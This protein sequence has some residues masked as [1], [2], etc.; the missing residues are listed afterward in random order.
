M[1]SRVTHR[2]SS[3]SLWSKK[4]PTQTCGFWDNRRAL[5][6]RERVCERWRDGQA[7]NQHYRRTGHLKLQ[8]LSIFT[9]AGQV[10]LEGKKALSYAH[11]HTQIYTLFHTYV[12]TCS[13]RRWGLSEWAYALTRSCW[14]LSIALKGFFKA[15][16]DVHS[17]YCY[18]QSHPSIHSH[19]TELKNHHLSN[20]SGS[21]TEQTESETD[22]KNIKNLS[23]CM[24]KYWK[25]WEKTG[26]GNE[27]MEKGLDRCGKVANTQMHRHTMAN[28]EQ[29]ES[30]CLWHLRFPQHLHFFLFK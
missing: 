30:I 27:R 8:T 29:R 18:R 19:T 11:S 10:N 13:M 17:H 22:M 3:A 4:K 1:Y 24:K 21:I 2:C 28:S 6:K 7:S 9:P 5:M 23:K 15:F 14:W 25:Q 20:V 12:H 16:W 26:R